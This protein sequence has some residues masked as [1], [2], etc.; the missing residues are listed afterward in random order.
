MKT[1]EKKG[2]MV[3][4]PLNQNQKKVKNKAQFNIHKDSAELTNVSCPECKNVLGIDSEFLNA[5]REIDFKFM[6]PYC[7]YGPR[8]IK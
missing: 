8:G 2:A 7:H 3:K 5:V 6:C 1:T 4:L